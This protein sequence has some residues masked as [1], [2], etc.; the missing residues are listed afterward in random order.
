MRLRF[1]KRSAAVVVLHALCPLLPT[2]HL[3]WHLCQAPAARMQV[4]RKLMFKLANINVPHYITPLRLKSLDLGTTPP[5]L[6]SAYSLPSPEPGLV[7]RLVTHVVYSGACKFVIETNVDLKDSPGYVSFDKALEVFGTNPTGADVAG[8]AEDAEAGAQPPRRRRT[9]ADGDVGGVAASTAAALAVNDAV[10]GATSGHAESAED[11]QGLGQLSGRS[12]ASTASTSTVGS[13]GST[14]RRTGV[15]VRG[16]QSVKSI[17]SGG[18]LLP[19]HQPILPWRLPFLL[20]A[21]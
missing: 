5:M 19:T 21:V 10:G 3:F 7:P 6:K 2:L 8:M 17:M 20:L 1:D 9:A 14:G 15:A 13:G 4:K 18:A 11:P 12:A 16:F